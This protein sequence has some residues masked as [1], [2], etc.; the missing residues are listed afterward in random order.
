ML[1][2]IALPDLMS[3]AVTSL[4]QDVAPTDQNIS[5][6]DASGFPATA[7][8][9]V[10]IGTEYLLVTG[11]TG[12]T[13]WIVTRGSPAGAHSKND[14]V[15]F[16]PANPFSA[17]H[18]GIDSDYQTMFVELWAYLAD[19]LT[20]YQERI[21]NEAFLGT[22]TQRDS[23]LRLVSLIDYRPSPGRRRQRAR[24]FHRRQEPVA[25]RARWIPRRKP[26]VGRQAGRG[27]RNYIGSH[28]HGRQQRDTARA[29][30]A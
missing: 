18:E 10:K 11:S 3:G 27:V 24:R 15:I 28:N 16:D 12:T 25:H 19:V 30:F 29:A 14:A 23:L 2:K 5:I 20:F 4:V 21:A 9:R 26:G 7:P 1:D 13:N 22:A 6:L 8:F 17:W